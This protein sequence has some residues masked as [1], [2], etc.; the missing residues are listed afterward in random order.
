[1]RSFPTLNCRADIG[2]MGEDLPPIKSLLISQYRGWWSESFTERIEL[3]QD[4]V[5]V[6]PEDKISLSM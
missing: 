3:I 1:M 4:A 2:S 5:A 6:K